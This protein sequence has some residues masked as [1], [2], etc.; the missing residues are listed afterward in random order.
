M[1][2]SKTISHEQPYTGDN[3]V[4][5]YQ[6]TCTEKN[7]EKKYYKYVKDK[8]KHTSDPNMFDS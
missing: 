3:I 2:D 7:T 6:K 4:G 5:G 8:N 1:A